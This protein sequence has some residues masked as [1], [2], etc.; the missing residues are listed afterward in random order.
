MSASVV[1]SSS[2]E[3]AVKIAEPSVQSDKSVLYEL[4]VRVLKRETDENPLIEDKIV[5]LT[6][7][8]VQKTFGQFLALK[9]RMVGADPQR[10]AMLHL[11]LPRYRIVFGDG[12]KT[13]EFLERRRYSQYL[14]LYS[15]SY[16][17][18]LFMSFPAII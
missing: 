9:K 2:I 8:N 5:I 13:L 18:L 15:V 1:S 6:E 7:W 11:D 4:N 10:L 14:C 3:F 16:C 12:R 17:S